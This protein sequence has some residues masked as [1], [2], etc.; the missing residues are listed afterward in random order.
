MTDRNQDP[1]NAAPPVTVKG[2]VA[3][4]RLYQE[5]DDWG[6][7][8]GM[9]AEEFAAE[10]DKMDGV[11][12]IEMRIN[13]RG[14]SVFD[15][16]AI[17]NTLRAHPASTVATVEGLAASAA[18]FI[19]AAA[20]ETVM[21]PNSRMMIHAVHGIAI[22]NAADLRH[23][24]DLF[25]DLTTNI[26]EI[27]ERKS[28]RPAAEWLSVMAAGDRWYTAD[29]AVDA[30]LA[31]RVFDTPTNKIDD[32]TGVSADLEPGAA[33]TDETRELVAAAAHADRE[34]LFLVGAAARRHKR[35]P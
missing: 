8:W 21:M 26:A 28:G 5:I 30:G 27:Y 16:L 10:L 19:A 7:D 33:E 24:A 22:G 13:S 6:A 18:S 4:V 15:A 1:R 20:D 17:V 12:R 29:E 32:P 2:N 3:T 31:D 25:D 14:G 9:S 11:D 35:H 34:R 23:R